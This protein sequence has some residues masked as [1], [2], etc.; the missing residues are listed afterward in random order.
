MADPFDIGFSLIPG[1]NVL[2][3]D[4]QLAAAVQGLA[5]DTG[6]AVQQPF[7]RGWAFDFEAGEFVLGGTSPRGVSG[8]DQLTVWIEKALR[9]YR[10]AHP[11]Y[12]DDFGMEEP[13]APIGHQLDA[14]LIGSWAQHAAEALK[15]HDRITDVTGFSFTADPLSNTLSA[16]FTV[17]TDEEDF[18]VSTT[19][20]A[21]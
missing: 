1:D 16:S 18:S 9:T 15:V 3:P 5:D 11:I 10:S 2:T 19:V 7:G 17:V 6:A 20:G 21:I 4:E 8:I 13:F 14:A 12:S